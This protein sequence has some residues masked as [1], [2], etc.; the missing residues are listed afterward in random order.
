[1]LSSNV[2]YE[3][4]K[5]VATELLFIRMSRPFSGNRLFSCLAQFSFT[6]FGKGVQ[7]ISGSPM[8]KPNRF[9]E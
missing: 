4:A 3:W 2:G 9:P 8:I 5:P 1:M 7:L 6:A